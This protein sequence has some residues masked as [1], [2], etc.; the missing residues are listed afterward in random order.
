MAVR[1]RPKSLPS[2]RSVAKIESKLLTVVNDTASTASTDRHS[3]PKVENLAPKRRAP[4][5]LRSLW[6]VQHRAK[7]VCAVLFCLLPI[8]YGFTVYTQDQWKR[9][10]GQLKRLQNQEIEQ[11]VMNQSL[12]Q[13][14]SK[15]AES[16][17]NGLIDPTPDRIVFIPSASPRPLKTAPTNLPL[18]STER[19]TVGY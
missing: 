12:K 3:V 9:Q 8:S 6:L 14:M 2:S 7:L 15:A 1:R 10:H 5:W 19:Q 17:Q 16:P 11:A 18:I 4:A 13:Q